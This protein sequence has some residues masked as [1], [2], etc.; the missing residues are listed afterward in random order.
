M[1][2]LV[3]K[4]RLNTVPEKS[5]QYISVDFIPKLLVSRSYNSILVVCDRFSKMSHFIVITEK[6]I[7]EDLAKLYKDNVWKLHR[8]LERTKLCILITGKVIGWNSW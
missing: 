2:M 3:R 7:V 1:K 4:L 8:L 5:W 6:I